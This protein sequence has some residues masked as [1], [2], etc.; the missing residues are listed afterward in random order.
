M[1]CVGRIRLKKIKERSIDVGA[2]LLSPDTR[3][4]RPCPRNFFGM[5]I[6]KAKKQSN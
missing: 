1:K 2:L 5:K 3:L 4:S 6:P